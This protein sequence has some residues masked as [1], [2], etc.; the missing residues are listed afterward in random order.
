LGESNIDDCGVRVGDASRRTGADGGGNADPG[1]HGSHLVLS[2]IRAPCRLLPRFD[3]DDRREWDFC[4]TGAA[5]HGVYRDVPPGQFDITIPNRGDVKYQSAHFDLAAGQQ[6][7]VKIILNRGFL[8]A[9][10]QLTSGFGA[11]LV[12]KQVAEAEV[13]SLATESEQH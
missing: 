6:A 13:P 4:W 8:V 10:W 5:G 3:T 1:G 9:S 7:Y 11:L 12:P 2:R